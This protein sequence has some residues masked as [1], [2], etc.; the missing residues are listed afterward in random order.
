MLCAVF[1][2]LFIDMEAEAIVVDQTQEQWHDNTLEV[3]YELLALCGV[4]EPMPT[5]SE[6]EFILSHGGQGTHATG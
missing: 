4:H 2:L 1:S 6:A 5:V 3:W